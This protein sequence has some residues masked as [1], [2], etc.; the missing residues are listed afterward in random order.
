MSGTIAIVGAGGIGGMLA[1]TLAEAG[2]GV[3][4]CVRSPVGELAIESGGETRRATVPVVTAPEA[5]NDPAWLLVTTKA[6]DTAGAA[7]W[8][9]RAARSGAVIVPV[10]NGVEHLARVRPHSGEAAVLPAII[11]CSVERVAP[12][13]IRHHGGSSMTVP[14]GPDGEA[15]AALF[16]GTRFAVQRTDDFATVAWRKLLSNSVN[17][18]LTALTLRRGGGLFAE[19]PIRALAAAI[20]AE[21][22]AVARAEGARLGPEDAQAVLGNLGGFGPAG[23]S[24]MLYDRL[25]GRPLEHEHLTGAI[26]RA[27]ARHGVPVPLNRALLALLAAA[28]GHPLDG[29]A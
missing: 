12:G 17:N 22:V 10:Q 25:A 19:E 5:L 6:Q 16:A 29:T 20:L 7:P 28:S 23:G 21:A 18:P 27:G 11:Y 26:V 15:F 9:E 13:H 14:D 8:I 2:R 4:L 1:V 3:T 24:S